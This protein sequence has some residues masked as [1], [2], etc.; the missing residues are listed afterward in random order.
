M[1]TLANGNMCK[2]RKVFSFNSEL[3]KVTGVQKV[4]MDIHHAVKEDYDAIIVGTVSYGMVD[5][6][7]QIFEDEYKQFKNPFMFY[8]SIV[9]LHER[10]FLL[11]FWILVFL[12]AVWFHSTMTL[13]IRRHSVQL[14]QPQPL[15]HPL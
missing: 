10:K 5:K 4:L 1:N 15:C 13:I 12:P 9:V 2:R 3:Y 14:L 6:S 8:D 11:L 7:H